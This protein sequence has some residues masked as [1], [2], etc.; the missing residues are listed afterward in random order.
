MKKGK[1]WFW[2]A[3][4]ALTG[5]LSG[6]G[7]LKDS[8]DRVTAPE[9]VVVENG[10]TL[11]DGEGQSGGEAEPDAGEPVTGEQTGRSPVKVKGIYISAYVAGTPDVVDSLLEEL[12]RTEANALVMHL[13]KL[14]EKNAEAK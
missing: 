2:L 7:A 9:P 3:A 14:A 5:L 10:Q 4:L 1:I 8:R 11:E 6:C 13:K 12:D